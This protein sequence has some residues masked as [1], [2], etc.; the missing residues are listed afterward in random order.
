MKKR[1]VIGAIALFVVL[2]LC[3]LAFAQALL[4]PHDRAANP[5]AFLIHESMEATDTALDE[6]IFI[7]D[8][9]VYESFSPV[10]LWQ[11]YGISAR[12]Y[13]SPQQL[14]WHSYAVLDAALAR[15]SPRVVVLS[16]YGLVYGSPQSEAY[17]R[18]AL[19]ALPASAAKAQVLRDA[20]C[21]EEDPLSYLFPLLRYH[22]RWSSLSVQDVKTLF[23]APATVSSR[24]FLVRTEV[25]AGDWPSH[26]GGIA[27]SDAFGALAL[28]YFDRIVALCRENGAELVLVKAPTDSWRY[29]WL[30]EYEAHIVALAAQ[31]EL[32]Y[33]NFL[34]HLSDIDYNPTTDS[35]DGGYHLNVWGAEKLTAYFGA[36]LSEVYDL[37]DGRSDSARVDAWQSDIDRYEKQKGEKRE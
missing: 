1:V 10:T 14:M 33:Y 9:E 21:V 28:E 35:C 15:S 20:R 5:D 23:Q 2:T 25:I 6:V 3:L 24:G 12:V 27:R 31:Y 17:A 22:D 30:D 32:P 36:I 18:M 19:E 13:G 29:P 7:G 16:V 11:Q 8:C 4:T 26:E 37:S 34:E